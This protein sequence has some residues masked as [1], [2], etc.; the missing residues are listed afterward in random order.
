MLRSCRARNSGS[1][2]SF[3]GRTCA[4]AA[5]RSKLRHSPGRLIPRIHRASI[6]ARRIGH[7]TDIGY[8]RLNLGLAESV[9][10]GRHESRLAQR[11]AAVADDGSEIGIADFVERVA[12]GEGMRL[13]L[14]VVKVRDT[15]DRRLGIVTA[16][17]VLI[18][19]LAA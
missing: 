15:L 1:L 7:G 17:A 18:V 19:E 16:F 8:Q 2:I 10:P 6:A 14:E 13:D 5:G 9:A 3:A 11:R 12:L 4:Q